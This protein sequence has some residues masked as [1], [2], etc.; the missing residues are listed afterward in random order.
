VAGDDQCK[1]RT[2][3]DDGGTAL[4]SNRFVDT[5]YR[6]RPIRIAVIPF[7]IPEHFAVWGSYEGHLG[8]ELA[9][10]FWADLLAAKVEGTI[11]LVAANTWAGESEEFFE[12]N[13][14]NIEIAR[15][16]GYS[17][18][19]LGYLKEPTSDGILRVYT[20]LIDV[21]TSHTMWFSLTEVEK[22][23]NQDWDILDFLFGLPARR[24]DAIESDDTQA[25][26][27]SFATCTIAKMS[28][29]SEYTHRK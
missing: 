29:R 15:Q 9:R 20:K 19:I 21:G 25:Q 14:R 8:W 27:A 11:E 22:G 4:L 2:Y 5:N 10:V 28:G 23:G 12:G 1:I 16:A 6:D 26:V 24:G 7:S 13:Y 17:H 3:I 18:I